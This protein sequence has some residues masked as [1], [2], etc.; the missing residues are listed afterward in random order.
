M[1]NREWGVA[2]R[3]PFATRGFTTTTDSGIQ[4]FDSK[5]IGDVEVMGMYTGFFKDMST[6]ITF[7]LKFPTGTY[8]AAGIDRD[9]Q[10]GSGSTDLLLGIFHRGMLTGDNAWQYFSQARWQVPFVYSYA[11]D[12]ELGGYGLYKPGYQVDGAFGVLY[13]NWYNVLGFDKITPL[14]QIIA[15]HRVHDNGSSSDPL[16]TGFDR[17]MISPGIEFTKVLDEANNRVLKVYADVEV[18]IYYRTNA[19]D[20]GGPPA[21]GGTYGQ[22]IAPYMVKVVASYNF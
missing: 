11:Y 10:I 19:A 12:P 9:T 1:F 3:V 18:P 7:G 5:S 22:L 17:L 15:S 13:N 20:N 4:T 16:N 14:A 2:V 8:T 6:G 21:D